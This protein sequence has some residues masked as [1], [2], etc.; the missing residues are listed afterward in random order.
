[1]GHL[2]GKGRRFLLAFGSLDWAWLES[3]HLPPAGRL[4]GRCGG[5]FSQFLKVCRAHPTNHRALDSFLAGCH[6]RI[7]H[8]ALVVGLERNQ[9][10]QRDSA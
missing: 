1:M 3:C 5:T 8:A 9:K 4:H 2:L 7:S 10:F 6:R